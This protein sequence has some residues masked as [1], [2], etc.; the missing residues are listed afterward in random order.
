MPGTAHRYVPDYTPEPRSHGIVVTVP[1]KNKEMLEAKLD[2]PSWAFWGLSKT[3][4][5][6]KSGDL[7]YICFDNAIR[8]VFVSGQIEKGPLPPA[9]YAEGYNP[10]IPN[11]GIRIWLSE[12]YD[13][14]PPY[15]YK[16]FQGFRYSETVYDC[17]RPT[18]T[19][20]EIEK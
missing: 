4:K 10:P 16:G 1:K 15:P 6:F 19:T 18:K 17:L 5:N 12:S 7:L 14:D 9:D 11:G 2:D 3:P 20:E 13:I 8:H